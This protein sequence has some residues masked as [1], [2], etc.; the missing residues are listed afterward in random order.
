[1]G[2]RGLLP[3][4]CIPSL[5]RRSS[6]LR[7]LCPAA[8]GVSWRPWGLG[9]AARGVSWHPWGLGPDTSKAGGAVEH[10]G[11]LLPRGLAWLMLEAPL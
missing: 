6:N 4:A 1:M 3:G 5:C 10:L 9:P 8:H 2:C 7:G 11:G